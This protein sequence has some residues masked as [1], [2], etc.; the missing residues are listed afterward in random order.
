[1]NWIVALSTAATALA[2]VGMAV[3]TWLNYRMYREMQR[4]Q[5][6]QQQRFNDLFEG[7]VIAT[8]LSGPTAYGDYDKLKKT[9]LK[10]YKGTTTIFNA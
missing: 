2:T 7:I 8:L 5:A 4:K 10:E 6:E 3:F 1:M 9:F